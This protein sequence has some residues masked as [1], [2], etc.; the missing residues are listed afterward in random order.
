MT[1]QEAE[2]MCREFAAERSWFFGSRDHYPSIVHVDDEDQDDAGPCIC[3]SLVADGY[4]LILETDAPLLERYMS[5]LVIREKHAEL[6]G[7][8]VPKW[9]KSCENSLRKRA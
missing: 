5:T 2:Q 6:A 8:V 4:E 7:A 9:L 3:S 1:R